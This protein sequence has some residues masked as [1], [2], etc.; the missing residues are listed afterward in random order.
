MIS[1]A[2][3]ATLCK[4]KRSQVESGSDGFTPRGTEVLISGWVFGVS[5]VLIG[6]S[7]FQSE[8]GGSHAAARTISRF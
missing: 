2:I 5:L 8:F 6:S 7:G 4:C 3:V 1:K